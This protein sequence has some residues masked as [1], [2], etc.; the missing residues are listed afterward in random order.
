MTTYAKRTAALVAILAVCALPKKVP[1]ER[2]RP[3]CDLVEVDGRGCTPT[4]LEPYGIYLLELALRDDLPVAYR[5][6]L[7]C[8]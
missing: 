1:C 6:W 4:D 2:P 7:D 5:T 8:L 3:Q